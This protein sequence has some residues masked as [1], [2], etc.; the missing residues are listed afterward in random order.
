[1]LLVMGLV[2]IATPVAADPI[3]VPTS[4]NPGD[5]YRLAFLTS[6][7]RDATSSNIADYNSF[8]T[9]VANTEP[10][11][12][13]LGTTWNAIG[14]TYVPTGGTDAVTN[15]G[16]DPS[17]AG[18]TG[19]PIFLLNDTKLADHYDD[20]WDGSV[21]IRLNVNENG[22]VVA[23]GIDVWTGSR[24]NGDSLSPADN[25][26]FALGSN[27]RTG[28]TDFTNGR[29]ISGFA[30]TNTVPRPLYGMSGILTVPEP[31]SLILMSIGAIGL[32]G[33]GR[34]RR[35]RAA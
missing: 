6:T 29:W 18:D 35:K 27:A 33:F 16:T 9:G 21:D 11:L 26:N 25:Q 13:A 28:R 22:D 30:M 2:V 19:V 4:L 7:T 32:N 10:L 20:L 23:G 15:T 14:S 34:R 12:V 8:V 5:Q 24:S 3:V 31:G 17:A 1:M